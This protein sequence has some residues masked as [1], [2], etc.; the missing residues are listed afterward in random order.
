MNFLKMAAINTWLAVESKMTK[1]ACFGVAP[2]LRAS[3]ASLEEW[4]QQD[5][6][7]SDHTR[8]NVQYFNW[9]SCGTLRYGPLQILANLTV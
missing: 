5:R 4:E 6:T 7:E 1:F 3:S 9:L 8:S 2:L